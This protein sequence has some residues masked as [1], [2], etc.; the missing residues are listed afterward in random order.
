MS[1]R[2]L[3]GRAARRELPAVGFDGAGT[4]FRRWL[5]RLE[6]VFVLLVPAMGWLVSFGDRGTVVSSTISVSK[7][8]SKLGFIESWG[9]FQWNTLGLIVFIV[10]WNPDM[11]RLWRN[12][13]GYR[14]TQQLI[15]Q[16]IT[17]VGIR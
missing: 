11:F 4:G 1:S 14:C 9:I 13:L 2:R 6:I 10:D 8:P 12:R 16:L 5:I 3:G 15:Q 17:F 7:D